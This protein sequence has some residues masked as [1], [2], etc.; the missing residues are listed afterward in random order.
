MK[1]EEEEG[2]RNGRD[3]GEEEQAGESRKHRMEKR[4]R[5]RL[6]RKMEVGRG[7]QDPMGQV[8]SGTLGRQLWSVALD[9][10]FR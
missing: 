9:F 5:R 3:G 8:H 6:W 10:S 4:Q 1:L 2:N 7:R